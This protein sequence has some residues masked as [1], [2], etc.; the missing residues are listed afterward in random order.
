ME[1]DD[2]VGGTGL[3]RPQMA[4][5]RLGY[6]FSFFARRDITV[7]HQTEILS[8]G[9]DI[10]KQLYGSGQRWPVEK[11]R[12]KWGQ[13]RQIAFNSRAVAVVAF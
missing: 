12:D 3:W 7:Y 4:L 9:I 6:T 1:A 2:R 8:H 10:S 11:A 13:T 5:C